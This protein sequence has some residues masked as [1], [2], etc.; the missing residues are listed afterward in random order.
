ME[1]NFLEW[2]GYLASLIILISLITNSI[3]KLRWINLV[4]ASLFAIYGFLLGS[5]PVAVMNGGIVIINMY[6]L[7]KMYTSKEYFHLLEL[8]PNSNFFI[9]FIE[10]YK[11]DL[12]KS[13]NK[14]DYKMEEGMVGFYILR[15]MVTAGVFLAKK[16][17]DSELEIVLDYA[18]AEYRDSKTGLYVYEKHREFFINNGYKKLYVVSPGESHIKYLI[19]MGFEKTS[20]NEYVKTY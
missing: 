19:R 20:S 2:F 9:H 1:I 17:S 10:F 15:N 7:K 12:I 6:Y 16:R 3:L 5:I 18:V 4:G 13:F 11:D 14:S 8:K